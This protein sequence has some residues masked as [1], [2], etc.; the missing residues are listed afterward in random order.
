M[1]LLFS[2]GEGLMANRR[3]AAEGGRD[4]QERKDFSGEGG[5]PAEGSRRRKIFKRTRIPGWKE[6]SCVD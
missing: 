6:G 1:V 2:E 3:L 4:V 5:F